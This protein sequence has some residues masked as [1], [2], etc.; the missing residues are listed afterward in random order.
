MR[1]FSRVRISPKEQLSLSSP[2]ASVRKA[3]RGEL[4]LKRYIVSNSRDIPERSIVQEHSSAEDKASSRPSDRGK[5]RSRI[6]AERAGGLAT[7]RG[8]RSTLSPTVRVS[9]SEGSHWV[10]EGRVGLRPGFK[11]AQRPR[12]GLAQ[13]RAAATW[14]PDPCS[15]LPGTRPLTMTKISVGVAT[16]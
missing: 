12:S 15:A 1:S 11:L 13:P 9:G 4:G 14:F 16:Q 6:T 8:S 5:R 2:V 10:T 7:P 3:W